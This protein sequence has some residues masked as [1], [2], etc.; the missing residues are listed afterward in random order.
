M[1]RFINPL[2]TNRL[3][4]IGINFLT[5]KGWPVFYGGFPYMICSNLV[6]SSFCIDDT[7]CNTKFIYYYN[8]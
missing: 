2:L 3:T 5:Y 8:R 4:D 7:W 1:R 6:L